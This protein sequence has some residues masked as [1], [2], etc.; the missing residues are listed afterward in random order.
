M[1]SLT[2]LPLCEMEFFSSMGISAKVRSPSAAPELGAAVGD[3][4]HEPQDAR[5]ADGLLGVSGPHAGESL[6]GVHEQTGVVDY[7]VPDP[8]CDYRV[9]ALGDHLLQIGRLDLVVGQPH[10]LHLYA[11]VGELPLILGDLAGI[12]CYD[13]ELHVYLP[14]LRISST[15]LL[16]DFASGTLE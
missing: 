12:R 11:E 9:H 10:V 2:A 3:A 15:F 13:L 6:Q 8:L 1:S 16:T 5:V 7:E 14:L 4:L